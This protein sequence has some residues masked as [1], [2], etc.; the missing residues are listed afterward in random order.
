MIKSTRKYQY[1]D[2]RFLTVFPNKIR[3]RS[4]LDYLLKKIDTPASMKRLSGSG[5]L[6]TACTAD[7]VDVVEELVMRLENQPQ[8]RRI[9]LCIHFDSITSF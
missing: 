5:R 8:T 2:R 1:S 9:I 7:N 3:T 6:S 4:G